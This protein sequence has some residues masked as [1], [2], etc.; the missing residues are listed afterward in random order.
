MQDNNIGL[1][2]SNVKTFDVN[3]KEFKANGKTYYIE[4]HI[5]ID[6]YLMYRKLEIQ[7]GYDVGFYGMYET[8][9]K[10][11]DLC[12]QQKFADIAVLVNNT[13]NGIVNV[14][15]RRIPV[16]DM[17]ALFINE[18]DEDRGVINDEIIERKITDWQAEGLSI[19]PFFQ[20]STSFI[21]NFQKIYTEIILKT[22]DPE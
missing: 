18:K 5:S 3:S 15:K 22:S 7:A 12:N 16:L 6:R 2:E 1:S 20:L 19:T 13:I 8:L 17:A 21:K 4:S 14:D 9:K 10:C 11:Y